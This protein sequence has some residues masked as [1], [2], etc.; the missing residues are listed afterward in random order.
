MKELLPIAVIC[1]ILAVISHNGSA[2]D[3]I[4]G[5]YHAKE[6]FFYG[7]MAVILILFA[8]LRTGY[9]DTHTYCHTYNTIVKQIANYSSLTDGIDW[10]AIGEN[11]GFF[12]VLR[13]MA[14]MNF[15]T[16]SAYF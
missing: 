5:R 7:I 8:G 3:P 16:Q 12:L 14:K 1:V 9:N 4:E 2:Y 15:S 6:K 11:P 10:L 13:L